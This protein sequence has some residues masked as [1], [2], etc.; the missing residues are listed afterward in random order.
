M[1]R[2]GLFEAQVGERVKQEQKREKERA[3]S[4]LAAPPL[5]D[6]IRYHAPDNDDDHGPGVGRYGPE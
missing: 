1:R 3:A 5:R 2:G 6:D 4:D